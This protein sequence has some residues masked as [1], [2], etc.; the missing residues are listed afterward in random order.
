MCAVRSVTSGLAG[1]I[2]AWNAQAIERPIRFVG[3]S[4]CFVSGGPL[5]ESSPEV[6]T[7][8]FRGVC[9]SLTSD[10]YHLGKINVRLVF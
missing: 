5:F 3:A 7:V 10:L 1:S 4:V 6:L 9:L 2:C 8:L